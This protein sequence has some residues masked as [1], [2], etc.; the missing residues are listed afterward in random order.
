MEINEIVNEKARIIVLAGKIDVVASREFQQKYDEVSDSKTENIILDC[1]DVSYVSSAGLR[2]F[3]LFM[4]LQNKNNG[5]LIICGLSQL[6]YNVFEM[7][8]FTGLF[9]FV[10]SRTEALNLIETQA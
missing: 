4:K 1:T 5:Q 2:V 9:T 8:G 6:V 7:S 10:S 3:L